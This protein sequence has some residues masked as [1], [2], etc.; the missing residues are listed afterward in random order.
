MLK[1]WDIF[2]TLIARRCVVPQKIFSIV[3]QILN[4]RNFVPIRG[5]AEHN[6]AVRGINYN[7]DDIYEEFHRITNAPEKLCEELKALEIKVELEQCIPITENLRQV[8]AGDILIS[9]MYLPEKVI[10]RMLEKAGLFVPVEIV[11]T[12]GGKASGRIWKQLAEQNKFVFHIGDNKASDIQRPQQYGFESALPI[13]SNPTQFELWLMQRDFNFGAYLREIRLRN[14]FTEEIKRTYW[15][16]FTINIGI[17][18]IL[19]QLIDKLQKTYG[20]EYLGFCGRDT[21][22]MS[23]LYHKYKEYLNEFPCDNDYLYYSRKLINHSE[24]NMGK[25]FSSKIAGRK[26]LM[27]DLLGTGLHLSKLR[28]E[29]NLNYSILICLLMGNGK[30]G[31]K[32][33]PDIKS[34]SENWCTFNEKISDQDTSSQNLTF[35]SDNKPF[36]FLEHVNRATHN[37]PIRLNAI[38]IDKKIIPDVTFS[39]VSDTH[40]ENFDVFEKCLKEVLNSNVSWR[41]GADIPALLEML[42]GL[43]GIFLLPG[44]GNLFLESEERARKYYG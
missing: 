22:Y 15:T 35:Y 37:T 13:S 17:L 21:Y 33:Y 11:I 19:V 14:P 28:M 18:I 4:V 10:R 39:E 42:K 23:L 20:F 38:Q 2:D 26:T 40:T 5:T 3:E 31:N 43:V 32:L 24:S 30:L 8:K 44:N 6:V 25:Y 7:L 1:S 34:Y 41:G 12:S 29:E 27:I 9:D 36:S 16:I